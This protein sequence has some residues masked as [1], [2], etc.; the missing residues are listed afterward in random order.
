VLKTISRTSFDLNRVLQELVKSAVKLGHA[1]AGGLYLR[2][3]SGVYQ[4]L[5]AYSDDPGLHEFIET[6]AREIH[7]RPNT[8][9]GRAIASLQPAQIEDVG[10][11]PGYPWPRAGF[12]TAF[13]VPILRDGS[14]IGTICAL[15]A[16][17]EPFTRKQVDLI[18]T[19]A[20]Q[21]GIAIENMRLFNEIREKSRQLEM[22]NRHK[23]EFLANVSH[24]LRTPLNA[25]IG[26]SEVLLERMFG[27]INEKQ[28]EYLDDIHSSGRTPPRPD[29]RHP[30]PFQDRGRAHGPGAVA[31]RRR[32]R[33]QSLRRHGART[34]D[35]ARHIDQGRGSA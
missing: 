34:R 4:L 9:T 17:K 29:Q 19:F 30:E 26:F 12:R 5:V 6:H 1:D 11:E 20:D 8:A 16:V 13:A 27:E 2:Q 21:A 23:S 22:A 18:S 35:P 3:P 32:R 25:V 14:P 15:K 28:A 33:A 31:L 7:A 24:E 10:A